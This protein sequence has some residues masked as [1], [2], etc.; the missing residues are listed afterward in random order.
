MS[1]DKS[2]SAFGRYVEKMAMNVLRQETIKHK[3][4][5]L[6]GFWFRVKYF[7]SVHG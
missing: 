5:G 1:A 7:T 4:L 3:A 2:E 6:G